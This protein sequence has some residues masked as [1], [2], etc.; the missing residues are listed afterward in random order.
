MTLRRLAAVGGALALFGMGMLPTNTLGQECS[1]LRPR[2]GRWVASAELYLDRAA[3]PHPPDERRDLYQ[4]ALD[5]LAEGFV[6]QPEN[7]QNYL[8]AGRA[9]DGLGDYVGADSVWRKAEEMWSCYHGKI[10]TLRYRA[11]TQA[12][13]RGVGYYRQGE[14]ERAAEEYESAYTVY[15]RLPQPMLQLGNIY[16]QQATS[17]ESEEDRTQL[18]Q[19]AIEAFETA[20]ATME[21]AER[22]SLEDRLQFSRAGYFNL[23]QLLAFQQRYEEAAR[24]YEA[25]L[26]QEAGNVAALSNAAVVLTRAARQTA[27]QAQE[28]EEGPEKEALL[29]KSD[30]LQ[31]VA[32]HYYDQLLTREDLE[33]NDYHNVGIGLSQIGLHTQAA[34]A[35]GKALELQ[36]YRANSLEDLGLALFY[37]QQYDTLLTVAQKLVERYPLSENNLNLLASA[38]RELDDTQIALELLERRND[39][40][41]E[42]PDQHLQLEAGEGVFTVT[43]VL[44]NINLEPGSSVELV[45]DF[46]DDLGELV[47][48]APLT[49]DAPEQGASVQFSVSVESAAP[50]SGFTYKLADG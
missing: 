19:Q 21:H 27:S 31:D 29:A 33:A 9:Y 2:G 15:D 37:G 4:Q 41:V 50:I 32:T 17:A 16:A 13:N 47:A 38:Y 44:R 28:L 43:G 36:P 12:F 26:A 45:F 35:F 34:E 46:Y 10:D 5:V 14:I 49:V 48:S 18:Q 1:G 39:L 7:P 40:N 24:A 20:M 11:W 8:L 30:S 6:Q 25:F 22:L 23:A 42:L 3:R